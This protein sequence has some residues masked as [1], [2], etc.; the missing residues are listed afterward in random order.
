MRKNTWLFFSKNAS[1]WCPGKGLGGPGGEEEGG[2]GG[3]M[4][5]GRRKMTVFFFK[6]KFL[7]NIIVTAFTE[8]NL[9]KILL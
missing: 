3:W 7:S 6:K 9:T 2:E 8:K 1:R 4:G 5:E